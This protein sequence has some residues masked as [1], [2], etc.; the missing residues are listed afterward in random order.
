M[1]EQMV[2]QDRQEVS[3]MNNVGYQGSRFLHYY[4][5]SNPFQI[6]HR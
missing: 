4:L 5:R 3:A 2:L 6:V 1:R